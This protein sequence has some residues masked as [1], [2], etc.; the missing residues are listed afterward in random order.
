MTELHKFDGKN[1]KEERQEFLKKIEEQKKKDVMITFQSRLQKRRK[2]RELSVEEKIKR[3][4]DKI[5]DMTTKK[6]VPNRVAGLWT[7]LELYIKL[8]RKKMIFEEIKEAGI[9]PTND[10]DIIQ[11]SELEK[12]D[13]IESESFKGFKTTHMQK[14]IKQ[15]KIHGLKKLDK[16]TDILAI[17]DLH[18]HDKETIR[19]YIITFMKRIDK[20]PSGDIYLR[21]FI[22]TD[23]YFD[24]L[25]KAFA[26]LKESFPDIGNIGNYKKIEIPQKLLDSHGFKSAMKKHDA[27]DLENDDLQWLIAAF[28]NE[29]RKSGEVFNLAKKTFRENYPMRNFLPEQLKYIFDSILKFWYKLYHKSSFIFKKTF[30]GAIP[31]NMEKKNWVNHAQYEK[32]KKEYAEKLSKIQE[33]QKAERAVREK[34]RKEQKKAEKKAEEMKK[35]QKDKPKGADNKKEFNPELKNKAKE[36]KSDLKQTT[37]LN[38][39]GAQTKNSLSQKKKVIDPRVSNRRNKD[40][41]LPNG[42]HL[43]RTLPVN[44]NGNVYHSDDEFG[45]D[46][47]TG[48]ILKKKIVI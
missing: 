34:K 2:F 19:R 29:N 7:N 6:I 42:E 22:T 23:Y 20:I 40:D 47:V 3:I 33:K 27:L 41:E 21:Q 38:V 30:E 12:I 25:K 10:D 16:I 15:L 9:E 11:D 1:W 45:E 4:K 26:W 48:K 35:A 18:F 14:V 39:F 43:K 32:A 31:F 17:G 36:I 8:V 37:I 13:E 5:N 44:E 46:G 28:V 24:Q